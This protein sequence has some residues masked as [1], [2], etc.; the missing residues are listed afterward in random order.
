LNLGKD[1]PA[2]TYEGDR[3]ELDKDY[4]KIVNGPSGGFMGME[5]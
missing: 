1:K 4:V 5:D 2:E 3:M